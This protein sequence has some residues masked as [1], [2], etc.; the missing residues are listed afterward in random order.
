[1]PF[2]SRAATRAKYRHGTGLACSPVD[3]WKPIRGDGR[4]VLDCSALPKAELHVHIE[5]TFEP[6][7]VFEFARRN[8]IALPYGSVAELRDRYRFTDLGSFL[9]VYYANMAVLRTER[10]FRELATAYLRRCVAQGVRRAEIF[11]DP[12]AHTSRGVPLRTVV[13]GL[14]QALESVPEVSAELI[15]CFLRDQPVAAAEQTLR[16]AE[17]MLDRIIGVGLDSAEVD[18]PP[19]D[20]APVFE[21][22]RALGLRTV[23]H[24][25]EEG[26]PSYVR[27]ALDSLGVERIDHGIRAL[28]DAG[29]VARLRAERTPLTVCPLSNVRLGCVPDLAAHPLPRMLD[30]GL[31]VTLN[32]DD[33]AY[34]GGYVAENFTAVDAAFDLTGTQLRELAANSLRA[35]FLGESARAELLAELT[36]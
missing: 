11:F 27:E 16:L 4:G 1:M 28:E 7:M 32:S 26:P 23:A 19:Q 5:G 12:Q 36:P 18:H 34:F 6:E 17:P 9:E 14:V 20:F 13:D 31:M 21:R 25:G 33:P 29:L 24:A 35:S 15:L 8:E 2:F 3:L 30:E 22:A 10:D